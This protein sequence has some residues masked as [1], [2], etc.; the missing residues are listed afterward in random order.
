MIKKLDCISQSINQ[1]LQP[2]S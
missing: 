1:S 2:I